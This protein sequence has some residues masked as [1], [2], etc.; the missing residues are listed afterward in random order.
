MAIHTQIHLHIHDTQTCILF[1]WFLYWGSFIK[2]KKKEIRSR[3]T[4]I[5]NGHLKQLW[6]S[7]H[8]VQLLQQKHVLSKIKK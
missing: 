3:T 4:A 6:K 5:R 8:A 1:D 2:I 7:F